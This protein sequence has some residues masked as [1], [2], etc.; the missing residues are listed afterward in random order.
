M[1]KPAS[2][3]GAGFDHLETRQ[4]DLKTT[5]ERNRSINGTS[6]GNLSGQSSRPCVRLTM[7]SQ[8][9]KPVSGDL[10]PANK[11][12]LGITE[13]MNLTSMGPNNGRGGTVI[14]KEI[15]GFGSYKG[16]MTINSQGFNNTSENNNAKIMFGSSSLKKRNQGI[17]QMEE[18]EEFPNRE[19]PESRLNRKPYET[20]VG[21][22]AISTPD[23]AFKFLVQN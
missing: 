8:R 22:G 18:I 21:V 12:T 16:T 17:P 5:F 14:S 4:A 3:Y 2:L 10:S 7:D 9:L 23:E 20:T 13:T 15:I 1:K 6:M 11:N 19:E